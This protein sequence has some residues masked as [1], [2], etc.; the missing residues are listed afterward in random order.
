MSNYINI[1]SYLTMSYQVKKNIHKD[2]RQASH[3][4]DMTIDHLS[5]TSSCPSLVEWLYYRK[6]RISSVYSPETTHEVVRAMESRCSNSRLLN[7]VLAEE[8]FAEGIILRDVPA[9]EKTF[10]RLINTYPDGNAVDNA[11]SWMAIIYRCAG[12]QDRAQNTNREIVRK[13][14]ATRHAIYAIERLSHPEATACS[15]SSFRR[16]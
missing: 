13:F 7:N 12:L 11:Y 4:I 2:F 3:L 9:A 16:F 10:A 15:L 5:N 14:P 1:L 8:I 6:A